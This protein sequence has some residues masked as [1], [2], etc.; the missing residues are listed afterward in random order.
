MDVILLT[1][2]VAADRYRTACCE[3]KHKEALAPLRSLLRGVNQWR[4]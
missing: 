3:P 2:S 1:I 4:F